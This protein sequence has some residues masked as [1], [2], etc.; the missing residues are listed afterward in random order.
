M[1]ASFCAA[2][3]SDP[4]AFTLVELLVVIGIIAML[5]SILLPT[6]AGV[7]RQAQDIKC[8]ATLRQLTAATTMYLI[9]RKSYPEAV[10]LSAFA[11]PVPLAIDER[12]LNQLGRYMNWPTFTPASALNEMPPTVSCVARRNMDTGWAYNYTMGTPYWQTGYSYC[13]GVGNST[14]AGAKVLIADRVSDY[15]GLRRRV[16]WADQMFY[17]AGGGWV[18]FHLKGSQPIESTFFTAPDPK[19]YRG[20]YRAW[21][22]GSVDWM[23][24][25]DFSLDPARADITAAYRIDSPSGLRLYHYW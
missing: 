20:H 18:Y 15:K 21:S 25:G 6:L 22:D 11:G 2:S 7:R 13:A 3:R 24:R 5:V 23:N 8:A 17:L 4:R 12:L 16:I 10:T 14:S 19:A 1:R 9:D